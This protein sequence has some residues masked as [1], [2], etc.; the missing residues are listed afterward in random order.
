MGYNQKANVFCL[1]LPLKF[2]LSTAN[3]LSFN[4][5]ASCITEFHF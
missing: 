4:L 5:D 2:Y 3:I 1:F